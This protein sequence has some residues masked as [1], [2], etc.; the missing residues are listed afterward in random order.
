MFIPELADLYRRQRPSLRASAIILWS[1]R[2]VGF[3][4]TDVLAAFDR[5]G[6]LLERFRA[7]ARA[8]IARGAQAIIPGE[9]PLNVLLAR[10]GRDGGRWRSGDRQPWSLGSRRRGRGGCAALRRFAPVAQGYFG[11]LADRSRRDEILSFYG[12]KQ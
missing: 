9:A 5:P 2:D 7:A 12:L 6:A 4:F 11:A 1:A 10:S 8:L 3:R